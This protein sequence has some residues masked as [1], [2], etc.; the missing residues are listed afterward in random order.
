M[1]EKR[2][3]VKK[4]TTTAGKRKVTNR[5]ADSGRAPTGASQEFPV[6]EII[7][8]E[9]AY[10][11]DNF[12]NMYDKLKEALQLDEKRANLDEIQSALDTVEGYG[13]E[14]GYLW[15]V[16][17]REYESFK[18]HYDATMLDLSLEAQEALGEMKKAGQISGQVTIAMQEA[19]LSKNSE[20]YQELRTQKINLRNQREV[21]AIFKN[22]WQSRQATLRAMKDILRDR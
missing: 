2:R 6:F 5:K 21:L 3:V 19:W 22:Q 17:N 11:G 4:K 8:Q 12:A 20:T 9:M 10:V 18:L 14:A 15:A 16:A 7:D 1:A 13:L